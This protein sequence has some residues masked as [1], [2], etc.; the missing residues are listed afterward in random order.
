MQTV[1]EFERIVERNVQSFR[2]RFYSSHCIYRRRM[3]I[4]QYTAFT[5]LDKYDTLYAI[6]KSDAGVG[7]GRRR[8]FL[9]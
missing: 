2:F 5:V 3:R 1:M 9:Y 6:H 8:R 4:Y 7:S